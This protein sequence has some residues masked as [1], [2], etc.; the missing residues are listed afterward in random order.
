M[1]SES[2]ESSSEEGTKNAPLDVPPIQ[3]VGAIVIEGRVAKCTRTSEL[4]IESR[5]AKRARV[6]KPAGAAPS[7]P[8]DKGKKAEEHVS[9]APDNELLNATKV[10]VESTSAFMAGMLCMRMFRG[11]GCFSFPFSG[12]RQPSGLFYQTTSD[13]LFAIPRGS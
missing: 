2:V 4:A 8:V 11:P 1:L 10:T 12:S 7:P 5:T 3:V 9:F 6:S 13:F